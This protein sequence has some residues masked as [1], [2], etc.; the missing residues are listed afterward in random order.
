VT[1]RLAVRAVRIGTIAAPRLALLPSAIGAE[2]A[3]WDAIDGPFLRDRFLTSRLLVLE[4]VRAISGPVAALARSRPGG[5]PVV[6]SPA[7]TAVSLAHTDDVVVAAATTVGAI[8]ID[9]ERRT[10][11]LTRTGG[12]EP[13]P[14]CSDRELL[15]LRRAAADERQRLLVDLWTGKEAIVKALGVGLRRDLR[16]VDVVVWRAADRA[17]LGWTDLGPHR[18]CIATLDRRTTDDLERGDT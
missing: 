3:R 14:F 11:S 18:I 12:D 1:R 13:L 7:G 2:R 4:A 15:D 10:R 5:P 6:A 9:V 8:G 16:T 17:R